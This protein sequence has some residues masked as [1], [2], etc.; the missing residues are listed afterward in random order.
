MHSVMSRSVDLFNQECYKLSVAY[1]RA[2]TNLKNHQA[3]LSKCFK[4]GVLL[5]AAHEFV[6]IRRKELA[7]HCRRHQEHC[8]FERGCCPQIPK[9][10]PFP[11]E[12]KRPV[13]AAKRAAP[14]TS[15]RIVAAEARST[16]EVV[17]V[18]SLR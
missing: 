12:T 17:G 14:V 18:S 16:P 6:T 15:Q 1:L 7:D 10:I 8:R 4:C 11:E 3:V 5:E 13:K 2:E 9:M